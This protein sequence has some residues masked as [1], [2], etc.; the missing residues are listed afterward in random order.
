[1]RYSLWHAATGNLIGDFDTEAAALVAVR[2]ELASNDD[3]DSLVLQLDREGSE[4]EFIASG[5]VLAAR[6]GR[7]DQRAVASA[8]PGEV[9]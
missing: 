7:H 3:V 1:M 6:A 2:D 9:A 4:P 5:Y 8:R